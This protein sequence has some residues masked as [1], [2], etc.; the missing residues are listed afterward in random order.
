MTI[1]MSGDLITLELAIT[2]AGEECY[3]VT[4]WTID[5]AKIRRTFA[6]RREAVK[7]ISRVTPIL[8]RSWK[9]QAGV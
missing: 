7:Y 1:A 2:D 4:Y 9:R 6:D 3:A 5:D 8:V